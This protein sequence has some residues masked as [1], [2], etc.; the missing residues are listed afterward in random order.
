MTLISRQEGEPTSTEGDRSE[1]A[2]APRADFLAALRRVPEPVAVVASDGPSGPGAVTVTAFSSVSADPPTILICLESRGSAA[3][4]II[5]NRRFTVN[6]LSDEDRGLSEFCAGHG[7][8]AHADRLADPGW[9]RGEDGLPAW[10]RAVAV[11]SCSLNKLVEIGSHRLLISRVLRAGPGPAE[12][13][14]LYRA[15]AYHRL[16]GPIED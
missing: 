12:A 6:F 16:S 5:E 15:R 4:S 14:L 10:G 7:G 9:H 3:R 1:P 13:P 2:A 8:A 11:L